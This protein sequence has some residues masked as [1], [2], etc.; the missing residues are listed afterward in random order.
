MRRAAVPLSMALLLAPA[1][2]SASRLGVL[3][4]L[5][6]GAVE[7][8]PPVKV[9]LAS[10]GGSFEVLLAD[11]GRFADVKADDG[12]WAGSGV[13]EGEA[14]AVSVVTPSQTWSGVPGAW[15]VPEA[16]R[17]LDLRLEGE[18]VVATAVG[19][20]GIARPSDHPEGGPPAEAERQPGSEAPPVLSE[21]PPLPSVSRSTG[22]GPRLFVGVGVG[23]LG[24]LGL[25][26]LAGWRG[27]STQLAE[28]PVDPLGGVET[29]PEAGIFGGP[30]P[31]LSDG[32][33]VWQVAENDL[34]AAILDALTALSRFHRVLV[35][36]P[37]GL[38][39]PSVGGEVAVA[40]STRPV[41]I[42]R[43]LVDLAEQAG[44]PPVLFVVGQGGDADSYRDLADAIPVGLGG[45]ALVH[46]PVAPELPAMAGMR[47]AE[48]W[49]VDTGGQLV[50]LQSTSAGLAAVDDPDEEAPTG[51]IFGSLSELDVVDGLLDADQRPLAAVLPAVARSGPVLV[52]APASVHIPR[53]RGHRVFRTRS[54]AP[55]QLSAVVAAISERLGT[56]PTVLVVDGAR[57]LS[58]AER[59]GLQAG[60]SA[61]VVVGLCR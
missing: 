37:R 40:S 7:L 44:P 21:V 3:V 61:Q 57:P 42:G 49:R 23:V 4:R 39:L 48:G 6:A 46:T 54:H 27:R 29:L 55:G 25:L 28:D 47:T 50:E 15:L 22:P 10:D 30:T 16:A 45:L 11:D 38:P 31:S 36:G 43:Q 2:S 60:V 8:E 32:L 24:L 1:L 51:P 18:Q 20:P 5:D 58:A 9:V 12:A 13:I 41:A 53:V 34:D 52:A 56:P 33:C 17:D 19:S 59:T 14:F 35:V 26:G